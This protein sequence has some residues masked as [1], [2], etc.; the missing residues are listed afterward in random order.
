MST[1]KF[2]RSA[3]AKPPR[4]KRSEKNGTIKNGTIATW[5]TNRKLNIVGAT[6]LPDAPLRT[7]PQVGQSV[8]RGN[9]F[10]GLL[11]YEPHARA[12][13]GKSATYE[14]RLFHRTFQVRLRPR[15]DR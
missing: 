2:P 7:L 12:L 14:F 6:Q 9:P 5:H 10:R 13:Q 11:R 15:Y 8:R 4:P 1:A 3:K